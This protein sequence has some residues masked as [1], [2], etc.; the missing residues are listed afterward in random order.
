MGDPN[1]A[2]FYRM[3]AT[4][5]FSFTRRHFPATSQAHFL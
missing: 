3:P 4:G 1:L 2:Q 5:E